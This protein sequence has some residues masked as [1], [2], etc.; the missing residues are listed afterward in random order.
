MENKGSLG[1]FAKIQ[2]R[3]DAAFASLHISAR[4]IIGYVTCFGIGFLIGIGFKRYGKWIVAILLGA[5]IIIACL[6]YFEF[7]SVHLAKLRC[8]LGLS[9]VHTL[10]DAFSFFQV[11]LQAFWIEM[12]LLAIAIAIGFKLG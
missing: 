12:M 9:G 4:D 10:D 11:K 6:Q 7:I 5:V 1:F 8:V 2:Q 3:V